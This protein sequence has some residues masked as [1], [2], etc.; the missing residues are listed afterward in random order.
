MLRLF[1]V[2]LIVA[3][4]AYFAWTQG[5]LASLGLAPVSQA[6]PARMQAQIKPDAIRLLNNTEARRMETTTNTLAKPA[7]C[8]QSPLLADNQ[9]SSVRAALDALPV[10]SWTLEATNAP[11][12]W[13]VYMG[14]YRD[15][16]LLAKKKSE[17]RGL[18]ISYDTPQR[19]GLL[20]GISLGGH[21]SQAEANQALNALRQKGARSARVA[22][23]L[24]PS[25][26][27]V[28]RLPVVDDT[29]R[30]QLDPVKAALGAQNLRNCTSE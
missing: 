28:L 8:L 21:A 12:R 9:A 25:Q 17:L 10:G 18:G 22:Q 1:V 19:D 24:A 20:P 7:E 2:L 11:G 29:L 27:Q 26:G 30:A 3:N 14:P 16:D 15:T 6:E 13:I 4:A 5:H 23:E